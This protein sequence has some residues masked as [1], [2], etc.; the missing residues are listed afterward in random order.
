[1]EAVSARGLDRARLTGP[2]IKPRY[3][4]RKVHGH[5]KARMGET[6]MCVGEGLS[7]KNH[8]DEQSTN[9]HHLLLILEEI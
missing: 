4:D 2:Y 8:P 7:A 1:M 3:V 9:H 6:R 5:N